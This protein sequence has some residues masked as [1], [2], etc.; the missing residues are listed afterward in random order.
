LAREAVAAFAQDHSLAL[1]IGADDPGEVSNVP[2]TRSYRPHHLNFNRLSRNT[3][4][5]IYVN[6]T[7]VVR[8]LHRRSDRT[9]LP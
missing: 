5:L 3:A 6:V 7:V 1:C 2:W 9:S 4:D 8:L